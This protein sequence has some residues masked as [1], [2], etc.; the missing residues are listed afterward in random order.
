MWGEVDQFGE[1]VYECHPKQHAAIASTKRFVAACAGT[2]G[3]KTASGPLW[4]MNRIAEYQETHSSGYLA[5]IVAPTHKILRRATIPTFLNIFEK[6]H[7]K[8]L[9]KPSRSIYVLP[10]N[11]GIIWTLSADNPEGPVGGQVQ[12]IW[13]DE[14]GQCSERVWEELQ[15]RTGVNRGHIFVTSTPYRSNWFKTEL[16]D[17]AL[18]GDP[19]YA[20]YIW[21]STDNPAYPQAEYERAKRT[22]PSQLFEMRYNARFTLAEGRVY[23]NF[24]HEKNVRPCTYNFDEPLIISSDFNVD[25]MCWIVG[26]CHDGNTLEVIDEIYIRNTNTEYTLQFLAE[27]YGSH[28]GGFKFFG[29]A[30]SRNRHTCAALSDYQ[31]IANHATFQRLGRSIYYLDSNPSIHDRYASVNARLCA[32]SGD[33]SLYISP[34]CIHLIQDLESCYYKEGSREMDKRGDVGHITDALGYCVYRLWP[35]QIYAQKQVGRVS[36]RKRSGVKH[37]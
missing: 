9:Y 22:L 27:K 11:L 12:D 29:D 20:A 15:Q 5:F 8:G 17:R 26:Q 18:M 36:I 25:P 4:L 3:G 35:I 19:D 23:Y 33:R 28:R 31:I 6:S 32:A 7:L 2:G 13:L 34:D 30:S 24:S 21:P 1:L 14:G 10:S 16:V 37:I